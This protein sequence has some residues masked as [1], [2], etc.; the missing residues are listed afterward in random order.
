V[1]IPSLLA[2]FYR[3]R[4]EDNLA[5]MEYL[6]RDIGEMNRIR[7]GAGRDWGIEELTRAIIFEEGQTIELLRKEVENDRKEISKLKKGRPSE[8]P[9]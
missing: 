9:A 7:E 8:S 2:E 6:A 3:E 5:L 1:V 4:I